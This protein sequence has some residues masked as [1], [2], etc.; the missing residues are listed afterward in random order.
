VK[1]SLPLHAP[2]N[3]RRP[4]EPA[5]PIRLYDRI[6]SGQYALSPYDA[7]F[8]H[9]AEWE[10]YQAGLRE[11]L[12]GAQLI[13]ADNIDDFVFATFPVNEGFGLGPKDIP[14]LVPPFPSFFVDFRPADPYVREKFR[15]CGAL[16]GAEEIPREAATPYLDGSVPRFVFA[17]RFFF[18]LGDRRAFVTLRYQMITTDDHG[19]LLD[20]R[21]VIDP[22]LAAMGTQLSDTGA[23]LLSG[24]SASVLLAVSF[25]N[26]QNSI[27][28]DQ[29]PPEKL[30]RAF[31]R[32][33]GRWLS[34]HKVIDIRPMTALIA[35]RDSDQPQT[36]RGPAY[37]MTK[38]RG[39]FKRYTTGKGLF[40]RHKGVYFWHSRQAGSLDAGE[41]KNDYIIRLDGK[42]KSK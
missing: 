15:E 23:D 34:S 24:F 22:S 5:A 37:A 25:L 32:K 4:T 30:S 29:S 2:T 20:S 18:T 21:T 35:Q 26:C 41:R 11:E 1:R 33:T 13:V 40:G 16:V 14:N 3:Q 36:Q 6:R 10:A 31:H 17:W 39:H 8:A 28:R 9:P 7:T 27:I 38:L 19:D 12:A 42:G